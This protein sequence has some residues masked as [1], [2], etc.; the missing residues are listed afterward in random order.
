MASDE[1][2]AAVQVDAAGA[3]AAVAVGEGDEGFDGKVKSALI[4]PSGTFSR[5]REKGLR[6][7][8]REREKGGGVVASATLGS[9][10]LRA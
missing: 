6:T 4:R 7:F 2:A 9:P 10:A 5:R 1:R 8:C 3:A